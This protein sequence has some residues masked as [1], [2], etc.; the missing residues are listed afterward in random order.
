MP[1][2]GEAAIWSGV[3]A[4]TGA[5]PVDALGVSAGVLVAG[6]GALGSPLLR[7]RRPRD[8]VFAAARL[9]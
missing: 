4:A 6:A 8:R 7:G 9:N 3:G 2:S 5:V 1:K